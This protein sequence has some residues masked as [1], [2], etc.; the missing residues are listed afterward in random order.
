MSAPQN[1]IPLVKENP[2]WIKKDPS[3]KFV[4]CDETCGHVGHASQLLCVPDNETMWCPIC[5]TI[6][7]VW[8]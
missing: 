4:C 3:W 5:K 7:W 8:L 6:D 2:D 1:A